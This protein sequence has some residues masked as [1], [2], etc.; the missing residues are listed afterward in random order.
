M[1]VYRDH[2]HHV[3]GTNSHIIPTKRTMIVA[4]EWV[5]R[6]TARQ[7]VHMIQCI[8]QM[9]MCDQTDVWLYAYYK[10]HRFTF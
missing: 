1:Y 5:G 8:N 3:G 4:S 2:I 9:D 10:S 6:M 7:H